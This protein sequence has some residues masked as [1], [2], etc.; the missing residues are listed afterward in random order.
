MQ[1]ESTT[2]SVS[3]TLG[4]SRQRFKKSGAQIE[5]IRL[6]VFPKSNSSRHG[7]EKQNGNAAGRRRLKPV[8]CPSLNSVSVV[9]RSGRYR[10][11]SFSEAL[12]SLRP[13]VGFGEA[14]RIFEK[15]FRL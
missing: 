14:I 8:P 7:S 4:F 12:A 6:F 15:T 11:D 3:K 2:A 9:R 1:T 5:A 10:F 13:W